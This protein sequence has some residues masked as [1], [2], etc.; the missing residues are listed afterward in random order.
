MARPAP[1]CPE[2]GAYAGRVSAPASDCVLENALCAFANSE[3]E[4][5]PWGS[6][7]IVPKAHRP[8]VFEL[9]PDEL[10]ATFDLLARARPILDERYRPD[11]FTIGWNCYAASGQWI[12]HA[13]LHVL[14]RFADEPRSGQGLRWSLRQPDN[15]RPDRRAPGTGRRDFL[16]A[17]S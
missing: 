2:P 16:D 3:A 8:T 7:I 17:Q 10:A 6:G 5:E 13:H 1:T 14:L 15:R 9:T 4:H 11:G 12:P